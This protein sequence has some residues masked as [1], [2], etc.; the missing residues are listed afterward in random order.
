MEKNCCTLLLQDISHI[1]N[2]DAWLKQSALNLK[3][4]VLSPLL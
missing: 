2:L 3:A 4:S 1:P